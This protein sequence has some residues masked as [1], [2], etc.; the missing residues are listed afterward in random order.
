M[1]SFLVT[2]FILSLVQKLTASKSSLACDGF[3]DITKVSSDSNSDSFKSKIG[4]FPESAAIGYLEHDDNKTIN[5]NC[6]GVLISEKFVLTVAH[7]VSRQS[8]LP[9]S[10]R[11]GKVKNCSCT[12]GLDR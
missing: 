11:L 8:N 4:E 7:C 12:I 9:I 3:G 5:Y 1:K 6:N 2:F 10:V